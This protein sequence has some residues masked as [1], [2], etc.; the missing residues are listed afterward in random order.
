MPA[1][2]LRRR[3]E[4]VRLRDAGAALAPA[5]ARRPCVG[6]ERHRTARAG[7]RRGRRRRSQRSRPRSG[8]PAVPRNGFDGY[9]SYVGYVADILQVRRLQRQPETLVGYSVDARSRT[10][11]N[12]RYALSEC[13]PKRAP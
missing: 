6:L 5:V 8:R 1:G 11:D 9:V 2:A 4:L 7:D 10:P 13:A 3:P 12:R